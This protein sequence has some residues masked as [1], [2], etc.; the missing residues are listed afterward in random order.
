MTFLGDVARAVAQFAD[1]RFQRVLWTGIGLTLA[2]FAGV[3]ALFVWGVNW[4]LPE[5]VALPLI[6]PVGWIDDIASGASVLGVLVLSVFLMVPVAALFTSFFLDDV[7]DAVEERHYPQLTPAPRLSM[8]AAMR[9]G[10][11]FLGVMV[12]ANLAA[13]VAYLAL[14]P[15]AP[16]IFYALNGYLLGRE[17]VQLIAMRRLG[18]AGAAQLRRRHA[19]RIWAAGCVM[20]FP[21][22]VPVVN[23]AVPLLGAAA[24]THLFH[25]LPAPRPG[26]SGGTS[27]GPAR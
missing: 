26:S 6:G 5:T 2:L 27:R 17:Y 16:V 25:R 7:T 19:L 24:F 9:D 18:R 14:P 8:V 12:L 4:L 13:L 22:T 21:L 23:L 15:L 10:L 3:A 20:A 11:A 1:P